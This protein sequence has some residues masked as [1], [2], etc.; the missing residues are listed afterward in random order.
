MGFKEN[1]PQNNSIPVDSNEIFEKLNSNASVFELVGRNPQLEEILQGSAKLRVLVK[2]CRNLVSDGHRILVFT[3]SKLMVDIISFVLEAWNLF[4]YRI[5]GST[6]PE[7]RTRI[8][9][10]FNDISDRYNGPMICLL[11]TKACGVGITLTGA[12]RVI[13]HDPSWN[14]AEV[15]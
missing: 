12:D 1:H 15:K 6:P 7:E 8:I 13:I 4:S 14:P 11:T 10:D 5:D 9:D 3:Q 2:L